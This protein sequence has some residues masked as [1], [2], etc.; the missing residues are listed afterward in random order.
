MRSRLVRE[1]SVWADFNAFDEDHRVRTSLRFAP[2]HPTEGEWVWLHD[3]EGN[4]VYGIVEHIEGLAVQIRAEMTTWRSDVS[5][6]TPRRRGAFHAAM[7]QGRPPT[8][9]HLAA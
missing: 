1:L 3:D 9:A 5:I 7:P 6:A 4:R 2:E 8:E